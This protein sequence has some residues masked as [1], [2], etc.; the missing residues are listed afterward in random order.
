MYNKLRKD[1]IDY[2]DNENIDLNKN[3]IKRK[4]MITTIRIIRL[5]KMDL[6]IAKYVEK[7]KNTHFLKLSCNH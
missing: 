6:L 5:K 3:K 2:I 1:H 4:M 7:I